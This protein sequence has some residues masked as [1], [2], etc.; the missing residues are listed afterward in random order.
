MRRR[1]FVVALA[2]AASV[3][4]TAGCLASEEDDEPS[5]NEEN[6]RDFSLSD[7]E[8]FNDTD[9]D[10]E[11]RFEGEPC[12][13]LGDELTLCY[14][15]VGTEPPVYLE[16]EREAGDPSEEPIEF[17]VLNE[18]PEPIEYHS[19]GWD[20]HKK[21]DESWLRI[22]PWMTT[23][24]GPISMSS[25]ES[26]A[27]RVSMSSIEGMGEYFSSNSTSARY[28]GS[29]TYA[30]SATVG[31]ER[32]P[33]VRLVSLFEVEDGPISFEPVG[34]DEYERQ[35]GVIH[36]RTESYEENEDRFV[37]S[38]TVVDDPSESELGELHDEYAVQSN[39][40]NNTL[41]FLSNGKV[42]EVRFEGGEMLLRRA[43]LLEAFNAVHEQ[44]EG[45]IVIESSED[46]T[47][48]EYQKRLRFV[49][50]DTTYEIAPMEYEGDRGEEREEAEKTSTRRFL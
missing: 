7:L 26:N 19:G 31:V 20:L 37:L 30:F 36:A 28:T 9:V 29:G 8:A 18:G 24:E 21:T 43:S 40:V 38:V 14:H 49:N 27:W 6:G 2:S 22:L 44:L 1:E 15:E 25:G 23:L 16:P 11:S 34:I 42:E 5:D 35:E 3:A 10:V 41:A 46:F 4:S 39:I 47:V 50:D 33:D 48:E 12:P 13:D 17:T 45:E 32:Y